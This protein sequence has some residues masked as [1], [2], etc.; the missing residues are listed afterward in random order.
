MN[1]Y[2]LVI[3]YVDGGTLK[4]YLKNN[5]SKLTWD[6]KY[7][8]AYQLACGISCLHN[9]RIVHRDLIII[10]YYLIILIVMLYLHLHVLQ[11]I[12]F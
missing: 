2:I 7:N 3:E 8:M 12:H 9:E 5:F 4:N 11:Y 6:D 10:Y 1:N